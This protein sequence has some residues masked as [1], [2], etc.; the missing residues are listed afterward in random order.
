MK[1]L[2]LLILFITPML[3]AG[4]YKD[5]GLFGSIRLSYLSNEYNGARS[6]SSQNNFMQEYKL[7]YRGNIYSPK[8]LDYSLMG[9]LRY[10]DID[11]KVNEQTSKT[12]VTSKD[13]KIDLNFLKE[14]KI[15]FRLYAQKNDRPTSVVYALGAIRT[16]NNYESTGASGSINFNI[17][18]FT[19]GAV[20]TDTKYESVSNTEDRNTKT[21]RSSIRKRD[22]NYNFQ[23]DHTNINDS[24]QREYADGNKTTTDTAENNINLVYRWDINKDFL[25]NTYS[26]Y[27]EKEFIGTE[28]YSSTTTSANANLKWDPKTKHTASLSLDGFNIEDTFN[29]TKSVTLRQRYAYKI[30]KNLNFSQQSDYNIITSNLDSAQSMGLG[31]GLSYVKNVNKDTRVNLSANVNVRSYTSDSNTSI[32]SDRYTYYARAGVAH[33][34]GSLNSRLNINIGYNGSNSTSGEMD[35]RYNA[36][37]SVITMLPSLIKNNFNAAYYQERATLRYTHLFT[38][39]HINKINVDDY[40]S[41]SSKIGL[42]GSIAVRVGASYSNIENGTIKIERLSPK[43]NLNFKYR[44]GPKVLFTSNMNLDTDLIYDITTY[45]SNNSLAFNSRKTKISLG[46]NYNKIVSGDSSNLETRDSYTLQ[47]RFERSF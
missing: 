6:N 24:V 34:I 4:T 44:F 40:L 9:L 5:S 11:S 28:S 36:D 33:D 45:R 46:Y 21:Y 31:S 23:L 29:S 37:L 3:F 1:T 12:K 8:L 38:N 22:R 32:N 27:R 2:I 19:Y 39:R 43:G 30:T 25:F 10:E 47:A 20:N 13:Y 26:Y 14:S 42:N 16:L 35:K 41:G 17:F 15:P 18:D 7:G